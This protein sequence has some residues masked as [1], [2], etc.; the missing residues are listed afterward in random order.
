M[1]NIP[2]ELFSRKNLSSG[3]VSGVSTPG[4]VK[5]GVNEEVNIIDNKSANFSMG[6]GIFKGLST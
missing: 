5:S 1:Y 4:S 3:V 2:N 6:G